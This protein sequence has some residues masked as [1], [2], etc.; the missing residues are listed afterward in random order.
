MFNDS[1]SCLQ[2]LRIRRQSNNTNTVVQTADEATVSILHIRMD[3]DTQIA[4]PKKTS[5]QSG[6]FIDY[7]GPCPVHPMSSHTWGDCHNNLKN[8]ATGGQHNNTQSNA[9]HYKGGNF[10]VSRGHGCG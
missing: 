4:S 8:K 6:P 5:V 9:H 2:L 3:K 7:K 10:Y 1:P